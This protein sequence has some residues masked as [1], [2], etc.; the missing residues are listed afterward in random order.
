MPLNHLA[1]DVSLA[2]ED[3]NHF[4]PQHTS[5][6]GK[7]HALKKWFHSTIFRDNFDGEPDNEDT[8]VIE[9]GDDLIFI[10]TLS[11]IP[12]SLFSSSN[13]KVSPLIFEE[14]PNRENYRR[15]KLKNFKMHLKLKMHLARCDVDENRIYSIVDNCQLGNGL[16]CY[17]LFKS[18][19]EDLDALFDYTM[20]SALEPKSCVEVVGAD[21]SGPAEELQPLQN[22]SYDDI[23][24]FKNITS[25]DPNVFSSVD[26]WEGSEKSLQKYAT[27][28]ETQG[29]PDSCNRMPDE[30][31]PTLS[32][33]ST[34][35]DSLTT[36]ESAERSFE[37][38][39]SIYLNSELTLKHGASR[40]NI[41]SEDFSAEN[42]FYQDS[43]DTR[44]TLCSSATFGVSSS[45]R[46][47]GSNTVIYTIPTFKQKRGEMNVSGIVRS[48]RNGTLNEKSLRNMFEKSGKGVTFRSKEFYDE[49][50]TSAKEAEDEQKHKEEASICSENQDTE[51]KN[52]A[53]TEGNGCGVTFDRY[54]CVLVYRAAKRNC[55][56]MNPCFTSERMN[57]SKKT[58]NIARTSEPS[59][60]HLDKAAKPILK[61]T[62]NEKEALEKARAKFCDKVDV[63]SFLAY[64][65]HFEHQKHSEEA[66]LGKFREKQLSHY[67]SKEFFPEMLQDR[68]SEI[69]HKS[70]YR[71]SKRA[72]ELNIGRKFDDSGFQFIGVIESPRNI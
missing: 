25:F 23:K 65:E 5:S 12:N 59:S 58:Y 60:S 17:Q 39:P 66:N 34:E 51:Y 37:R 7:R 63:K 69:G 26:I 16:E 36:S 38:T 49:P 61:K 53:A 18:E 13:K 28:S 41:C 68:K 52:E 21:Y 40:V 8:V 3:S 11:T 57:T 1:M 56:P 71:K 62:A 29:V 45:D 70:E 46:S 22:L 64:F 20:K 55:H 19:P 48:F 10:P 33:D 72:T 15:Q 6:T 4:S 42:T 44:H 27:I 30:D 24:T 32:M 2:Q 43:Q 47:D 67:Y 14:N 54:S 9:D 31:C 35:M 50:P